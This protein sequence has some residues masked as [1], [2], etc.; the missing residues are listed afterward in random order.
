[1]SNDKTAIIF[2]LL[3]TIEEI[4]TKS[5]KEEKEMSIELVLPAEERFHLKVVCVFFLSTIN[6]FDNY[7]VE[8]NFCRL[9]MNNKN[10]IRALETTNSILDFSNVMFCVGYCCC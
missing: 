2:F 4:D 8:M 1:M 7:T 3:D 5:E 9:E 10:E 6:K